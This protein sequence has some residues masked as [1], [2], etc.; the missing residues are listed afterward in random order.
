MKSTSSSLDWDIYS[1]KQRIRNVEKFLIFG[2]LFVV[3]YLSLINE[4]FIL[5]EYLG[6]ISIYLQIIIFTIS[7]FFTVFYFSS[8]FFTTSDEIGIQ[9]EKIISKH[10]S[11]I[12]ILL[13]CIV[14]ISGF[15]ILRYV[16]GYE[17]KEVFGPII[18]SLIIIVIT[19]FTQ[20]SE[21][22]KKRLEQK[23]LDDFN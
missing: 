6:Q 21:W 9:L 2:S 14:I 11:S 22:I 7:Y 12:S 10:K 19:K 15:L 8:I 5:E 20:T 23:Q 3:S 13:V 18:I 16:L 4:N 1:F 17:F